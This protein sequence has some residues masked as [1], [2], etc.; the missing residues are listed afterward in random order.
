MGEELGI[1]GS[2][3]TIILIAIYYIVKNA[4]KNGIKQAYRDITGKQT[5]DDIKTV[6]IIDELGL[7]EEA[8]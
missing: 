3:A 6:F 4:V 5:T 8:K 2:T 7:N 1:S